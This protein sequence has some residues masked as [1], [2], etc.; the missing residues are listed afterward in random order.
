M[1]GLWQKA[2]DIGPD[3]RGRD[4]PQ[5]FF[6]IRRFLFFPFQPIREGLRIQDGSSTLEEPDVKDV[7]PFDVRNKIIRTSWAKCGTISITIIYH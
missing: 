2:G 6:K 3:A 7:P 4:L 5:F 1:N